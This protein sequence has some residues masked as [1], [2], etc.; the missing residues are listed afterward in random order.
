MLR[1]VLQNILHEL[2]LG[3]LKGIRREIGF[4]G[5]VSMFDYI[6]IF[7]GYLMPYLSF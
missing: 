3:K 4:F 5:L 2:D 7:V 6:S 1:N